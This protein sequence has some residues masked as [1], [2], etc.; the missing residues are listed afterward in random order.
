MMRIIG[1]SQASVVLACVLASI[2]APEAGAQSL[3]QSLFGKMFNNSP[4]KTA[5][6]SAPSAQVSPLRQGTNFAVPDYGYRK[7][8]THQQHSGGVYRTVCVRTCDGYYFPISG[9]TSRY[10]FHKD[11]DA[12]SARCSGGKLYYLP[13]RSEN[14]GAMIDLGGRRY[15]Q[16]KSAFVY[17]KKLISGCACRPM[18][19]TAAERARHNRYAY[20][21]QILRLNEQRAKR[22]REQAIA[23]ANEP[24]VDEGS[25]RHPATDAVAAVLERSES[26]VQAADGEPSTSQMQPH[27]TTDSAYLAV[28]KAAISGEVVQSAPPQKYSPRRTKSILTTKTKPRRKRRTKRKSAPATGWS[29][30]GGSKYTWPGDR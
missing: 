7:P 15:D 28:V 24:S 4:P 10:K 17:R 14:M 8:E 5:P 2:A 19:W 16:L 21:E 23:R 26:E 13:R 18:P 25:E 30:A 6:S 12:C 3:F 11:A 27:E 20:A 9:S 1:P 22:L 29:S